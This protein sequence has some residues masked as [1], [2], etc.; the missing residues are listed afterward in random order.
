M[1][2]FP[3]CVF[4][5]PGV[6]AFGAGVPVVPCVGA[7][8]SSPSALIVPFPETVLAI[9]TTTPPPTAPVPGVAALPGFPLPPSAPT[10]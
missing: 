8:A 4:K 6:V 9:T 10:T 7:E 2:V 3:G 1:F 5:L